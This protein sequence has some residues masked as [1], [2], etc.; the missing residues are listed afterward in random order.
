MEMLLL[1]ILQ[2][3]LI[4]LPGICYNLNVSNSFSP[5]ACTPGDD[6]V[7]LHDVASSTKLFQPGLH[8]TPKTPRHQAMIHST[9]SQTI[10]DLNSSER[11]HSVSSTHA[12]NIRIAVVN[13]NSV[14]G[15][16]AEPAELCDS[17]QPD[18][19]VVTETKLAKHMRPFEFFPKNYDTSIYRNR[20]ASG[21]G[22]LIATKRGIIADEV[23]L[24]VSSSGEIVC[25]RIAM[26]KTSPMY[27]CAYCNIM[28][29]ILDYNH[30]L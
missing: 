11:S 7:F 4:C 28:P 8:S 25:A 27:I 3:S 17:T 18:I 21:G 10:S 20:T 30:S 26:A 2:H 16:R 29:I 19:M 23:T 9:S 22:V 15:R 6:S 14:K 24:Q 1:Q 12:N 13:A 5:L